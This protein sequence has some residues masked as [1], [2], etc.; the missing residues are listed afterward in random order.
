MMFSVVIAEVIILVLFLFFF[1]SGDPFEML[2][3]TLIGRSHNI[4]KLSF[5]AFPPSILTG[6]LLAKATALTGAR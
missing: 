1:F 6:A 3:A 4:I 2:A 5:I